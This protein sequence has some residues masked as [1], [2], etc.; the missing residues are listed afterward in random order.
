[1]HS[2]RIIRHL[3][4]RSSLLV[5]CGLNYNLDVRVQYC[6]I[7]CVN[8]NRTYNG[9]TISANEDVGPVVIDK[10]KDT[11]VFLRSQEW[12]EYNQVTEMHMTLQLTFHENILPF[13][14]LHFLVLSFKLHSLKRSNTA[15]EYY[16]LAQ[17]Q[18]Y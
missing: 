7:Y 2:I 9:C 12:F 15:I 6:F 14:R 8:D 4:E 10:P 3:N 18:I 1:M 13:E 17:K 11:D 16:K 5:N